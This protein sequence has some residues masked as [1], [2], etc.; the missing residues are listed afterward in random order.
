MKILKIKIVIL[1]VFLA[2][3]S[4]SP[5][6]VR[7]SSMSENQPIKP[8][9][10]YNSAKKLMN[11]KRYNDAI[12]TLKK[13]STEKN[14]SVPQKIKSL[15]LLGECYEKIG[16]FQHSIVTHEEARLLIEKKFDIYHL[17]YFNQLTLLARLYHESGQ[18]GKAKQYSQQSLKIAEKLF[19]TQDH[20]EYARSLNILAMIYE[21]LGDYDEAKRLYEQ[22]LKILHKKYKSANCE[23]SKIINNIAGIHL[24]QKEYQ[25][26]EKKYQQAISID[27][28]ISGKDSLQTA[29]DLNNLGIVYKSINLHAKAEAYYLSALSIYKKHHGDNHPLVAMT[30]NNLGEIYIQTK[31]FDQATSLLTEAYCIAMSHKLPEQIWH[32]QDSFR[33]LYDARDNPDLA[34]YFGKKTIN[35]IQEMR[36][37]L[38]SISKRYKK[39]F[40][41][42]K[43]S[44]YRKLA[45]LLIRQERFF[46]AQHVLD[47]L[48]NEEYLEYMG[49]ETFRGMEDKNRNT[50]SLNE[51]ETNYD[52]QSSSIFETKEHFN[53]VNQVQQLRANKLKK[54]QN[55]FL[56]FLKKVQLEIIM[57]LDTTSVY[58]DLLSPNSDTPLLD[59]LNEISDLYGYKSYL[60]HYLVT[61]KKVYMILHSSL[62]VSKGYEV[63]IDKASLNQIIFDFME[64]TIQKNNNDKYL[65]CANKLYETLFS[66]IAKDVKE[67]IIMLSLDGPLRY[68]P[69]GALYDGKKF[70]AEKY[71]FAIYSPDSNAGIKDRPKRPWTVNG[72]G[73]T[74]KILNFSELKFV[75]SELDNIIL[76]E[77]LYPEDQK[78]VLKGN[79]RLDEAFNFDALDNT[80]FNKHMLISLNHKRHPVLHIASHFELNP[81]SGS[82]SYLLL[83]DGNKFMLTEMVKYRWKVD[84]LSLSACNTGKGTIDAN[85]KEIDSF[86]SLAIKSGA[87]SVIA[88]LWKVYDE[89]TGLFM[90]EFYKSYAS[91]KGIT[92]L[93]AIQDTQIKFIHG[94]IEPSS[95]ALNAKRGSKEDQIPYTQNNPQMKKLDFSHPFFW[96]PFILFGNWL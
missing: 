22:C 65:A 46:E 77:N 53:E 90:Q 23:I 25:D 80:V 92:K 19:G 59:A 3:C 57:D 12:I 48:K 16:D 68:I 55:C 62:Y 84:L 31:V 41:K 63:Y 43:L 39:S 10:S 9:Y 89:S 76:E 87:K 54:S 50:I 8:Q 79:V 64:Q 94:Q 61:S 20:L 17:Q 37:H 86:A 52:I 78:G 7:D 66:P 11:D 95:F 75:A 6:N 30:L 69:M 42:S 24:R 91:Q 58:E 88:T 71:M 45:D 40:V 47:L 60:L 1:I 15:S 28:S 35:T 70:L 85:G 13:I 72:M 82:E 74:K 51:N 96:A 56:A 18:Y 38:S 44:A 49:I 2:G 34:I 67:G 73:I 29:R 81:K 32:V 33:N 93:K 26:A 83:G 36:F 27:R 21:S 4:N 5:V 14:F